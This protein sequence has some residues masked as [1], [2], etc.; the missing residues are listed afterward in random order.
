MEILFI[1]ECF[2]WGWWHCVGK[3]VLI[4]VLYTLMDQTSW[5]SALSCYLSVGCTHSSQC[6]AINIYSSECRPLV[7]LG[8][9]VLFPL[10]ELHIC[11]GYCWQWLLKA[12]WSCGSRHMYNMQCILFLLFL[13]GSIKRVN[14]HSSVNCSTCSQKLNI[15]TFQ[16]YYVK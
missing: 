11:T 16:K 6:I 4:H 12:R 3:R 10:T 5:S 14:K 15:V 7:V 9:R 13:D 1:E 8:V 2:V